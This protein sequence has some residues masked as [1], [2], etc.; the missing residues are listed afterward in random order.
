MV[1]KRGQRVSAELPTVV[2]AE[3]FLA[4]EQGTIGS[5]APQ[6]LLLSFLANVLYDELKE[7]ARGALGLTA[8]DALYD[9]VLKKV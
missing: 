6:N 3:A 8:I 9:D 4:I 5:S 2:K 7:E 1:T